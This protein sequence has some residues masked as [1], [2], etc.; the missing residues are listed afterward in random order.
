MKIISTAALII[1]G[2]MVSEWKTLEFES[3][4]IDVPDTWEYQSAQGIDSFVGHIVGPGIKLVFDLSSQGYADPLI[5]TPEEY[6]ERMSHRY[7]YVFMKP[8][9]IYTSGDVEAVRQE[10][11][12]KA[13]LA[14]RKPRIVEKTI[15]P[16]RRIY[17]PETDHKHHRLVD[18][19]YKDS[20]VTMV[21][22]LPEQI[23]NHNITVDT[24][25]NYVVKH[26]S[27]KQPGHGTTGVFYK[28]MASTLTF[29]IHGMNIP[30]DVHEDALRS[31]ASIK[32]KE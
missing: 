22:L 17:R 19:T 21:V 30:A 7:S 4:L 6:A 29:Q 32:I 12:K 9:V 18:L 28:S 8:S 3:F 27:P 15:V 26:I 31:L 10:E 24:I 23:K 16:T 13:K 20:T 5:D 25:G 11:E 1:L 2:T 14:N